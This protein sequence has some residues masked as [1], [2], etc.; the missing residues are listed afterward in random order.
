MEKEE[1]LK[2]PRRWDI[3][4][5]NWSV[6]EG[7]LLLT[8]SE[9]VKSCGLCQS[10]TKL[11]GLR[12]KGKNIRSECCHHGQDWGLQSKQH[13]KAWYK[14]VHFKV[15]KHRPSF[16]FWPRKGV[17]DPAK[18]RPPKRWDMC[19]KPFNQHS[20]APLLHLT[21][22]KSFTCYDTGKVL[23]WKH[24]NARSKPLHFVKEQWCFFHY[25]K[26]FSMEKNYE[27]EE[28]RAGE[29]HCPNNKNN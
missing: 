5:S 2:L 9:E 6:T 25:R 22:L 16:H 17:W 23:I 1:C 8:S 10:A 27:L 21:C 24:T 3:C 7:I 4:K 20:L 15:A 28:A 11:L 14:N 13:S 18:P 12:L 19:G 29:D 26:K